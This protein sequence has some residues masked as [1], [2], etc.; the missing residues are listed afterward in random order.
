MQARPDIRVQPGQVMA[1]EKDETERMDGTVIEMAIVYL[2][3]L[4]HTIR[5]S[6]IP[7]GHPEAQELRAVLFPAGEHGSGLVW[8]PGSLKRLLHRGYYSPVQPDGAD[9]A[10]RK[11]IYGMV[12]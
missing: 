5:S 9:A 4:K 11:I 2:M 7:A 8:E 3:L 6:E 10:I 1:K 12:S